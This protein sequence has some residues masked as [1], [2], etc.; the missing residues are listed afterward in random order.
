[1]TA[2]GGLRKTAKGGLRATARGGAI[3]LTSMMAVPLLACSDLGPTPVIETVT[4]SAAY[5]DVAVPI[6]VDAQMLRAGLV[7]DIDG[8]NASYDDGTL[9][10]AL[11][12][13]DLGLPPWVDLGPITSVAGVTG[14]SFLATVPA[15][16]AP[17]AYALR[18]TPPN[19]H[20]VLQHAAFQELGPD[21]VPPVVTVDMPQPGSTLGVGDKTTI[22]TA[23]LRVDD[24]FGQLAA[25]NWFASNNV[26]GSCPLPPQPLTNALPGQISCT[27]SFPIAPLDPAN[28]LGVP[29]SFNVVA[30]DVAM[31]SAPVTVALTV[32]NVPKIVSFERTY[33]ALAGQ[34]PLIIHGAYFAPDA[35]AFIDTNAIV[36]YA[37]DNRIGGDVRDSGTIVGFTPRNP[38]AHAATV[39]VQTM[40]GVGDGPSP[41]RYIA[42]PNPRLI[43]PASGSVDGGLL[44]TIAGN[45]LLEG[46]TISF[47]KT[48][49]TSVPLSSPSY[50]GDDKV[51]GC[52]PPGEAGP[53]TVWASDPVTGLGQ[54]AGAFTYTNDEASVSP[55]CLPA[56][57]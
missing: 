8:E 56:A 50:A 41:Y 28:G 9:H 34:Q 44:V 37:P 54:L 6:I 48:F 38:L 14:Q 51:V 42:P 52:L 29:F 32:A 13:D 4:P 33:G 2:K 24:G 43:Q 17:G 31:N 36:G 40:A 20:S 12:G 11:V 27:A 30:V 3:A 49:E 45:D 18:V 55:A 7:V 53:V 15:N 16:L 25:V 26:M 5:S 21:T 23:T 10:M 19:G 47:G 46:V 35:K 39:S 22:V 1:L 57:N